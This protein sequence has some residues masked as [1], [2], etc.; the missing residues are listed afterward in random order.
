MVNIAVA[1]IRRRGCL[2]TLRRRLR[3]VLGTPRRRQPA[4]AI[5]RTVLS[6]E[7]GVL[8]G[9]KVGMADRM[10]RPAGGSR[11]G[12]CELDNREREVGRALYPICMTHE[13]C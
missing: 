9:S 8:S 3:T 6:A 13:P 10:R 12:G 11:R 2:A 7:G 4:D 5:L 1:M